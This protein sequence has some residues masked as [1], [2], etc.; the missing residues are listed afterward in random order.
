MVAH[1]R[2]DPGYNEHAAYT[3]QGGCEP[4]NGIMPELPE[5]PASTITQ[6]GASRTL[7]KNSGAIGAGA[8]V[9]DA[10]A[11]VMGA[12]LGVS[13]VGDE[14]YSTGL[15]VVSGAPSQPLSLFSSIQLWI[16]PMSLIP[17][18]TFRTDDQ[19]RWRGSWSMPFDDPLSTTLA[20]FSILDHGGAFEF[21]NSVIIALAQ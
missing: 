20:M 7:D 21:T 5:V 2:E 1:E 19:G 14:A 15:L 18:R 16:D 9:L 8:S 3:V 6:R 11:W 13:L 17:L 4:P 10:D 12:R